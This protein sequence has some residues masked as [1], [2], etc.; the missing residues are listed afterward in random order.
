MLNLLIGYFLKLTFRE[1]SWWSQ[2]SNQT[3][4]FVSNLLFLAF[5]QC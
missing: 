5:I 4:Y 3:T 1:K 2:V